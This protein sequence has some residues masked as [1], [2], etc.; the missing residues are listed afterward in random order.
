MS[1]TGS[2]GG[3]LGTG[4][5]SRDATQRRG[6]VKVGP[7]MVVAG[8]F[9]LQREIAS[10]GMGVVFEGRDLYIERPVAI[11]LMH[12][13][14]TRDPVLVA[15]FR[16]EAQA[17]ARISHPNVVT[18]HEV[19]KQNDGAFYIVHEL[20]VGQ[21][22]RD[23]LED[24]GRLE[25]SE[26]FSIV[27]PIMGGLIAAHTQN[28]VHRDIK[29]ENIILAET[30][31][32]EILPKI[33]DFG[34]AKLSRDMVA[35]SLTHVGA[36]M[37]TPEYMAPEQVRAEK[38]D[39]RSDIWAM[40]VLLFEMLAGK[41]PFGG[42]P[43]ELLQQILDRP[44]PRLAPLV[45]PELRPVADVVE[46]ALMRELS[47]RI[48]TMAEFRDLLIA[49]YG[50]GAPNPVAVIA[51]MKRDRISR[52]SIPAPLVAKGE[53]EWNVPDESDSD[54]VKSSE[55]K[56]RPKSAPMAARKSMASVE[57]APPSI[58]VDVAYDPL[59]MAEQSLSVNSLHE[60]VVWA[61]LAMPS[62]GM[63]EEVRGRALMVLA[64]AHRWL[65]AHHE[66]ARAAQAAMARLP[67]GSAE[68]HS[69]FGHLVIAYGYLGR[70]ERLLSL[71]DEL[72]NAEEEFAEEIESEP[73]VVSLCRL[74]LFVLRA[75]VP[76]LSEK[77]YNEARVL[78]KK[79]ETTSPIVRAW[80]C[81]ARAEMSLSAGQLTSYVRAVEL[82]IDHFTTAGDIRSACLEQSSMGNA[83]IQIGG[84]DRAAAALNESLCI[85][86]PMQLEL[87]AT[88]KA[89]LG[90][91]IAMAG[92]TDEGAAVLS[93]ALDSCLK[94][95]N[96]RAESIARMY[97]ARVWAGR[98]G[99]PALDMARKALE[100][101]E[102]LPG[103]R[104]FALAVLASIEVETEALQSASIAHA[105]EA[106]AILERLGG[107][108]E[109]ETLI[110]LC[111][112]IALRMEGREAQSRAVL[113]EARR[114]LM[115][116]AERLGDTEVKRSFLER[117]PDH[118][119]LLRFGESLN[120]G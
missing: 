100:S 37:G 10:G 91:A 8:K 59:E 104:A 54:L 83:Y 46:R 44:I 75:G 82:A 102:G 26:V 105:H 78:T 57:A 97:L 103:R 18:V 118:A 87:V 109:G 23:L 61:E 63:S 113:T 112:A 89:R 50:Q 47:D 76:M 16:R 43:F 58:R 12:P 120:N 62:P 39:A 28:I 73:H 36:V 38:V 6:A 32:G 95:G 114:R 84:W 106:M 80:L 5:D 41:L 1:E 22:L 72:R 68:W 45:S 9:A 74:S 77:L 15:R 13:E 60:A 4:G 86:E 35:Q 21:T 85:A 111:H 93:A 115:D 55:Q 25:P 67:R 70:T 52:T 66:A 34:I 33:I 69:A 65:G 24:R 94:H 107:V 42:S 88:A 53:P 2:E 40:G 49:A 56:P 20:L 64:V 117:V 119:R 116:K 31:S 79:L 92:R 3:H 51:P 110:R 27:I 108:E 17:A 71:V 99:A 81:V 30:P 19:G 96:R 98:R 11:K 48:A 14:L 7:G 101:A 90:Y 29:P